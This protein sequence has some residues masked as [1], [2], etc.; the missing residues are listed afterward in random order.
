MD[1]R[2]KVLVGDVVYSM[3]THR[4]Y[5]VKKCLESHATVECLEDDTTHNILYSSFGY[6]KLISRL[7]ENG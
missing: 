5:I 7:D 3:G 6:M 2:G 4:Y 1:S